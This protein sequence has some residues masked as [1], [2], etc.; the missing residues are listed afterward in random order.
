MRSTDSIW[1]RGQMHVK[2]CKC[3]HTLV[4]QKFQIY[5]LLHLIHLRSC[6]VKLVSGSSVKKKLK[7]K[8]I[9]AGIQYQ[10]EDMCL[11]W[12]HEKQTLPW[13][14]KW[15]K[16]MYPPKTNKQTNK[17]YNLDD[18]SKLECIHKGVPQQGKIYVPFTTQ[19]ELICCWNRDA[20][21]ILHFQIP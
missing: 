3:I 19:S 12:T 20:G 8:K 13:P 7:T 18:H 15:V 1:R 5:D 4:S 10:G 21:P 2:K 16:V 6:A 9:R 11:L 17:N 14:Q